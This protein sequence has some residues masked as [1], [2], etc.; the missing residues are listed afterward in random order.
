VNRPPLP[1]HDVES[2]VRQVV[3]QSPGRR[4]PS[5]LRNDRVEALQWQTIDREEAQLRSAAWQRLIAR[6]FDKGVD[7]NRVGSQHWITEFERAAR[8]QDVFVGGLEG[9][10]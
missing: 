4:E 8:T 9:Y 10:D 6:D 2:R 1:W 3:S 5:R 7:Y